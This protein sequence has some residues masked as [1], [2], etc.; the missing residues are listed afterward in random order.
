M[1]K[2]APTKATPAAKKPKRTRGEKVVAFIETFCKIPQ[3]DKVGKPMRLEDFQKKFILDIYDNPHG[4]RKAYLSLARKNGKTALIAAILLAHIAGPEAHRNSQIIS[5]A[6]SRDQAALV[7]KLAQQMVMM[8]PQLTAR[9]RIIPSGKRLIGLSENVEYA[10][11]SA[12]AQTAFGL[13][14]VLAILDEVGQVRGP[15]DDFVSAITTSQGAYENPLLIAIS[16]QAPTDAD[17]FSL[18][19]DAQ[20]NAP[21]PRVVAHLYA[22]PANCALDDRS[23]WYAANPALGKFKALSDLEQKSREAIEMPANESDFR[24]LDL[25]Q[26]IETFSPFVSK[27][28]WERNSDSPGELAGKTVHGGLDL[29]EAH[30]LSALVLVDATGGV[31]STF[32]LP[33]VGLAE[34][35]RKD[36]VPWDLWAKEGW[37]ET[38]PGSAIEYEYIAQHLR[39]VFDRCEVQLIGFDRYHMNF[40]RPWLVKEGFSDDELDRFVEFGQGY[41]SMTPALRELEVRLLNGKL[42]HGNHPVMNM[43]AHNA[44]IEGKSGARK[45]RKPEGSRRIDGMPALAMAIGVM[46][47]EVEQEAEYQMFFS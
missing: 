8:E 16:T 1:S 37:L 43:C 24:N 13:S 29:S 27:A 41:A 15:R 44:T 36:R 9:V 25:N 14:P 3:G 35:S 26:R 12:E 38:T 45:F 40:L 20:A 30:D 17:M 23:A 11:L 6:R 42:K 7:F 21:D 4:T 39:G 31:H 10:A 34:K 5:G 33:K 28:V 47:V 22:A 32:W 18:W 46:P 2:A 19:L